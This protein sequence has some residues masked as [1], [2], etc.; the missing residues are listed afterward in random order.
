MKVREVLFRFLLVCGLLAGCKNKPLNRYIDAYNVRYTIIKK[1]DAPAYDFIF[2]PGG[3]GADSI[4]FLGLTSVVDFPG[5]CYFLDLPGNGDHKVPHPNYDQWLEILNKSLRH[6]ANP[7]LVGHSFGAMMGLMNKDLQHVLKGFVILGSAPKYWVHEAAKYAQKFD[8]PDLTQSLTAFSKNPN[9]Q[10][11]NAALE[12]C[13]PYYFAPGFEQEYRK[14]FSKFAFPYEPAVWG[15][16]KGAEWKDYARWIPKVPTLIINGTR[17]LMTPYYMFSQDKRFRKPNIQIF[18]IEGAGHL[19]WI[20]KPERMRELL[21]SF[22][23]RLPTL[24]HHKNH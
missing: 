13:L 17:D 15:Q 4:Y 9:Q 12:A 8:V 14:E 6:F 2:L 20:E 3:P 24:S 1:V 19:P 10:T 22:F 21:N 18:T 16:H 11:F 7:V 23:A 5:N